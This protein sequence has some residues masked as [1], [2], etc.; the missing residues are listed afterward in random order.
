M[1]RGRKLPLLALLF[2]SAISWVTALSQV[3]NFCRR[4]GHQTVVIDDKLYIDGGWVNYNDF[5]A[6]KNYSKNTD[7]QPGSIPTV[8]G[9]A[10]WGDNVNK[11]F[12]LYGGEWN[13]GYPSDPYRLLSY[14]ILYDRWEKVD[15]GE[16]NAQIAS[17]GAGVGVSQ[18]GMGYYYGG[19]ISNA[20]MSGWSQPRTMSSNFYQYE[21]DTKSFTAKNSPED[22]EARAEGAMVWIPAGD[23]QGL[24]VYMGGVVSNSSNGTVDPQPLDK[25]FVFDATSNMWSTQMATG[26][27]PQNR[28]Q[29]CMDVAWAPDKSSFNIYL[30][31]G[32]SVPPPVVNVTSFNDVYI[33]TLPSFVWIKADPKNPGNG[34]RPDGHYSVSCNMVKSMSQ[35]LIIGGIYTNPN[36]CDLADTAWAQHNFWTGT[37]YNEGDYKDY[38]G[39]FEPNRTS[40]VVPSDVYKAVGG[41]RYGSAT[42]TSPKGGYDP[43]NTALR[44]LMGRRAATSTRA[45]TRT[46]TPPPVPGP[47]L[48]GG[49]IAG[50]VIG[51]VAGVA[52]LLFVWFL[53]G[54][55][56]VRRR[57]ERRQS[58]ATQDAR[59]HSV[60]STAAP[61]S[62]AT[63]IEPSSYVAS[64]WSRPESP[65]EPSELPSQQDGR[66]RDV[67][68]SVSELPPTRGGDGIK[69]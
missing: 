58:V 38:W 34:T 50:I 4:F 28:R 46:P 17:Y 10:L 15:T 12:Y 3:D 7:S 54:R 6:H 65:Q 64:R 51:S 29:F 52:L 49:A 44:D 59:L 53:I 21:Y 69:P 9:G 23:A 11:K 2:L 14:D 25:I 5:R 20:S 55:R 13:T 22:N 68:G 37:R 36:A 62:M 48:S 63:S 33:L 8:S 47:G 57:E 1:A 45:P 43:T 31:G 24:L 39:L 42:Q 56:V 61:P 35:M 26:E 40:N 27:I 19:W 30:W 67:L 18:T 60:R 66:P 41:N 32:L 16:I